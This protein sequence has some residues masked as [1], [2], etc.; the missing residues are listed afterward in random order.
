MLKPG[1][2]TSLVTPY[3]VWLLHF[4]NTTATYPRYF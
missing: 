4:I 2:T 3:T 1:V